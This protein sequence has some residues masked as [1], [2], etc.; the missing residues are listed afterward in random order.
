MPT[1]V[2]LSSNINNVTGNGTDYPIAFDTEVLGGSFWDTNKLVYQGS[3]TLYMDI[4]GTVSLSGYILTS[5]N[6]EI[7]LGITDST[8]SF[9]VP[10]IL[11]GNGVLAS[12]SNLTK[13]FYIPL[14]SVTPDAETDAE[15]QLIV[16]VGG[17]TQ[18]VDVLAG[19]RLYSSY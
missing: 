12:A 2:T 11:E 5:T 15:I 3:S 1:L 14:I 13:N 7:K 17:I 16:S 8:G 9:E 19:S 4:G 10:I 6:T 18:G